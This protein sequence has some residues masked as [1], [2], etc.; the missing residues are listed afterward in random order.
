MPGIQR[1][2]DRIRSSCDVVIVNY[3]AGI[4]LLNAVKSSLDSE[5]ENAVWVVDNHST[6]G[7]LGLLREAFANTARL[8]ILE[9]RANLGFARACNRAIRAIRAQGGGHVLLLNPDCEV[10][11]DAVRMLLAALD[12]HP[13]AGVAGPL[14]LNP[15]GTEQAGGRRSVPTPWRTFVR[16][17]GFTRFSKR[18]PRV[19]SDFLLHRDPLP[20]DSQAVEAI[21]GAS[22]LVRK[23]ALDQV[24][25]LDQ[26]YFMHC[27]DLD[28]CMRFRRAE[29]DIL[30][31]PQAS[32]LHHKG[33]CSRARPIFVEWHKHRG[34]VRFYR[35][36]FRH[37]YPGAMMWLVTGGVWLRF[38]ALF[39]AHGIRR[40]RRTDVASS[41][42]AQ[43]ATLEIPRENI[44]SVPENG[45]AVRGSA[46]T[47]SP[48][49]HARKA[50]GM[51]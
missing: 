30:F 45:S 34:M 9:N 20:A 31:V 38:A 24:G 33:L 25:P 49:P 47:N 50:A 32:V 17:F 15:D 5:G 37:Q 8:H 13:R 44:V 36:F 3:N 40:L 26:R 43:A 42:N 27:E 7:S 22:M 16:A 12:T 28:W 21:S 10:E 1:L 29:W 18:Y 35:K 4:A 46:Y 6:D 41:E 14:L 39:A 51:D 23:E 19:F 11:P 2:S 48:L